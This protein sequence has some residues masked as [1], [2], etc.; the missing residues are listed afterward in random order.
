MERI[1][2]KRTASKSIKD[3]S[4]EMATEMDSSWLQD[5]NGGLKMIWM[6]TCQRFLNKYADKTF[7][8]EG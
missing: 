5:W 8:V 4:T 1:D 7:Q 6:L 3:H 2:L